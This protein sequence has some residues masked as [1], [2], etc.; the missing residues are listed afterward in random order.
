MPLVIF[1]AEA[2][3]RV[4]HVGAPALLV[5]EV[6]VVGRSPTGMKH[7]LLREGMAEGELH[8]GSQMAMGRLVALA[9]GSQRGGLQ[10]VVFSQRVAM[11]LRVRI[12]DVDFCSERAFSSVVGQMCFSRSRQ[13]AGTA[14]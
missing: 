3:A 1:S 7:G 13:P 14:L 5:A 6:V 2:V 4:K 11:C 10:V 12:A 8:G 9:V